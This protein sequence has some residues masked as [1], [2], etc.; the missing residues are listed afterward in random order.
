MCFAFLMFCHTVFLI[1]F[2][3]YKQFRVVRGKG[4]ILGLHNSLT[5]MDLYIFYDNTLQ[6]KNKIAMIEK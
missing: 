4:Y 5:E 2:I 6:I 3:N 1:K